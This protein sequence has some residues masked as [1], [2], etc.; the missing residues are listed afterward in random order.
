MAV[1]C[2]TILIHQAVPAVSSTD[3]Y[4]L[5][6]AITT[7]D[8]LLYMYYGNPFATA[9]TLLVKQ[10]FATFRTTIGSEN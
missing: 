4:V 10:P 2:N 1:C 9:G 6:P 8:T 7:G 5:V 3:L